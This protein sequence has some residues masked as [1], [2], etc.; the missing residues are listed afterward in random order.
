M[1]AILNH[2]FSVDATTPPRKD[3][4]A[5]PSQPVFNEVTAD[6]VSITWDSVP[7]VVYY[8]IEYARPDTGDTFS[9][10]SY[11]NEWTIVGLEPETFYIFSVSAV[12]QHGSSEHS[13]KASVFTLMKPG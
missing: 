5:T 6:S 13:E 9:D 2:F 4:P 7:N 8:I 1:F 3:V 12:N 11:S 10:V